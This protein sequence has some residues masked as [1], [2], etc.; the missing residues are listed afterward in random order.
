VGNDDNED[1]TTTA[2]GGGLTM[3]PATERAPQHQRSGQEMRRALTRH[4]VV[5][6]YCCLSN[7]ITTSSYSFYYH[8]SSRSNSSASTVA[9]WHPLPTPPLTAIALHPP[10][11]LPNACA[12][13]G[14]SQ[15][16]ECIHYV[17]LQLPL[18]FFLCPR[19]GG[20][21]A[22]IVSSPI[23]SSSSLLPCLTP[24]LL[25]PSFV[26]MAAIVAVAPSSMADCCAFFITCT[27]SS[28]SLALYHAIA[29]SCNVRSHLRK[30]KY[31]PLLRR[32]QSHHP[33]RP[34]ATSSQRR[35]PPHPPTPSSR[36]RHDTH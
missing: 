12:R 35:R 20:V 11:P 30:S 16:L 36:G 6:F 14:L 23:V 33:R 24:Y 8:L 17:L 31:Q 34:R 22:T 19:I 5:L 9:R 29:G 4:Y 7:L 21:E 25:L 10:P 28:T 2:T 32:L 3:S 27:P 13:L 26:G 1:E 18:H 15:K